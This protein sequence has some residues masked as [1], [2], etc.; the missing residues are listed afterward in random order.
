[1]TAFLLY[2]TGF[3]GILIMGPGEFWLWFLA[4]GLTINLSLILLAY[5]DAGRLSFVKSMRATAKTSQLLIFVL[6]L[7]AAYTRLLAEI[8]QFIFFLAVILALWTYSLF[9]LQTARQRSIK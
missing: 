8:P 5:L 3:I 4:F 6:A 1:M 2:L 9:E 7:A